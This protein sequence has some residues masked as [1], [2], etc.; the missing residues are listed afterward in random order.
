MMFF[1]PIR[2]WISQA[3]RFPS[4]L[5]LPSVLA[6]RK[7]TPGLKR[8]RIARVAEFAQGRWG[9]PGLTSLLLIYY[10]ARSRPALTHTSPHLSF[11]THCHGCSLPTMAPSPRRF[12]GSAG[13][14][15]APK[16]PSN[17]Q[18][19]GKEVNSGF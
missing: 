18:P 17:G 1:L 9:F 3:G 7:R 14:S 6:L 4:H 13:K 16:A 15:S 19:E 5:L 8:A 10:R 11:L 12:S 2:F